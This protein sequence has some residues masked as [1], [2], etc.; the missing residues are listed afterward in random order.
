MRGMFVL[1][2]I[3]WCAALS[4]AFAE[5]D[6]VAPS[7]VRSVPPAGAP[8]SRPVAGDGWSGEYR[9]LDFLPRGE[10]DTVRFSLVKVGD[11]YVLRGKAYE[12][13]EFVEEKPGLLWDRKH[14]IGTISR[15]RLT[16]EATGRTGDL[17]PQTVLNVQFCYEFFVLIGEPQR[18]VA[19]QSVRADGPPAANIAGENEI[20]WKRLAGAA[21]EKFLDAPAQKDLPANARERVRSLENLRVV[22]ANETARAIEHLWDHLPPDRAAEASVLKNLAPAN[23]M[24]VLLSGPVGGAWQIGVVF[25]KSDAATKAVVFV[26]GK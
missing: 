17:P 14:V 4:T 16:Y 23:A 18:E 7:P 13:Y 1:V 26:P 5:A 3:V 11:H 20:L 2:G 19:P 21:I 12:S 8:A 22:E 25:D 15:G 10:G 6:A 9:R 24:V